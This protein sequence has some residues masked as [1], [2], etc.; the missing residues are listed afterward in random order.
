MAGI[1]IGAVGAIVSGV[2]TIAGGFMQAAAQQQMAHS[3]VA[4]ARLMAHSQAQA[5][6]M[7]AQARREAATSRNRAL[8]YQASQLDMRAKEEQAAAQLEAQQFA[9]EKRYAQSALQARAAGSG[10]DATDPTTLQIGSEIEKYGTLQ[11]MMAAF[12]GRSRRAGLEAE[13]TGRRAEGASILRGADYSDAAGRLT[14][15][16]AFRSLGLTERYAP[17]AA[18]YAGIGTILGGLSGGFSR[19]SRI[20]SSRP[21]SNTSYR[22]G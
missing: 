2:A 22:Y 6:T 7:E 12:G 18:R 14:S 8:Q 19:F 5:A 10:F 15:E 4:S 11:E 3:Q 13:A 21:S 16:T 20:P 9:R 1:G 17:A